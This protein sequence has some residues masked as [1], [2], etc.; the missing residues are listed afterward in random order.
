MK[1]THPIRSE[2]AI[3]LVI[4]ALGIFALAPYSQCAEN[5][6]ATALAEAETTNAQDAATD[7]PR[8]TA[9][10][11]SGDLVL[12]G[13][14]AEIREG[15]TIP[16]SAVV[17]AGNLAIHGTVNG[18]AVCVGGKM[19]AGPKA[20]IGGDLVTV[21][22]IAEID[23][24]ARIG[25]S[26]VNVG[27]FAPDLIKRLIPMTESDRKAQRAAKSPEELK[28]RAVFF[29]FL[30]IVFLALLLFIALLMTTFLPVPFAHIAEHIHGD[31]GRSALLGLAVMVVFPL[32]LLILAVTVAGLP[33]IPIALLAAILGQLVGYVALGHALGRVWFG[34]KGPM[35]KTV[36]GLL[37]LQAVAILGDIISLSAGPGA[38]F[39]VILG[40]LGVLIF[41]V[42][43]FIGLGAIISSRGGRRSLA[44]TMEARDAGSA[45][46][47]L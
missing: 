14:S 25:G 11:T 9:G 27:S 39:A 3:A 34:S 6:N 36:A 46:A 15:E 8:A 21:G 40:A 22:S 26:K 10:Q 2:R 19:T 38:P 33:L 43:S 4:A 28:R 12:M 44:Q 45:V 1:S 29:F 7:H 31:F 35:I 16:G 30:E 32:L 13:Q 41:S 5:T 24:A 42:G 20:R 17:V 18:D 37:A 23:P 47:R